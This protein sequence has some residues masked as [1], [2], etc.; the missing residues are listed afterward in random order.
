PPL[1]M[2]CSIS[3]RQ[4]TILIGR[5][6]MAAAALVPVPSAAQSRPRD[7]TDRIARVERGLMRPLAIAGAAVPRF[8]IEERMRVHRTPGVSVAVLHN[9]KIDWAKGYGVR[10]AGSSEPVDS[11]TLFQA[12]SISKPV[13]AI[14]ALRLVDAGR[15]TLDGDINRT[16]TRWKVP[17]D[18]FTSGEKVTLRRLLSHS[19]GLTVHGFPGYAAG[20]AVPTTVQ[21][22]DGAQP[23]NTAAIRVNL[24]PGTLWRYSGGGYT[25]MQLALSD[26]THKDFPQLVR[27][28]VLE[29]VGMHSSG[30]EQPLPHERRSRAAL[31]HRGD[32]TPIAGEWHTYPEMAA[33]GLWTTPTD[34]LLFARAVQRSL[35]GEPGALLSQQ[36][37]R[38]F[39]TLQKG[40]Y[41][42]GV[43]LQGDSATKRFS[44]GGA[45]AGYRCLFFAFVGRS[46]GVAVMTNGDNGSALASEIARAVS[47]V[48]GWGVMQPR[49]RAVIDV[50]AEKL[51]AVA[52]RYRVVADRDT[53]PLIMYVQSGVLS[54]ELLPLSATPLR[55]Y[56]SEKDRY[57]TL[58]SS[59]EFVVERDQAG[60]VTAL[61]ILGLGMPLRAPRVP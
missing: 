6:A 15:L 13:A 1:P 33:A 27:E 50:A 25:V 34:L 42:L 56:A 48:Y 49:I 36:L 4:C 59:G 45:N 55:L 26:V 47:D 44:H 43:A 58:E 14:A 37:A 12:A 9:G 32:G 40:E 52:G 39:V 23:A 31:A 22:L 3:V 38:D 2:R 24:A 11:A 29:P 8:T 5:L 20:S 16:L 17:E 35:G 18:S 53:I 19:A 41:G 61:R 51:Q 60:A 10:R 46:D 30:Y 54:A 21:I 57:F 28:L 7:V